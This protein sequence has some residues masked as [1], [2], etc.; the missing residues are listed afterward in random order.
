MGDV[1]VTKHGARRS[2]STFRT[3]FQKVE[4]RVVD[5]EAVSQMVERDKNPVALRS[6]TERVFLVWGPSFEWCGT[7][8]PLSDRQL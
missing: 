4:R 2:P 7:F 6:V 8:G 1:N 3:I 5:F